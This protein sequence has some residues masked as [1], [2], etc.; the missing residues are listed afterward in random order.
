MQ[1]IVYKLYLNKYV[2]VLKWGIKSLW[3][4]SVSGKRAN[5][6]KS[7]EQELQREQTISMCALTWETF[8]LGFERDK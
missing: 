3:K 5:E 8:A 4:D 2:C 1:F 6:N 7:P